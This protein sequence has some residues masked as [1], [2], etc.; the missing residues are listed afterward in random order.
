ML[1]EKTKYNL[2]LYKALKNNALLIEL[3]KILDGFPCVSESDSTLDEDLLKCDIA[4]FCAT[5]AGIVA[6]KH[7]FLAIHIRLDDFFPM[8]P[9]F[10][11][12]QNMLQCSSPLQF[13]DRL[14]EIRRMSNETRMKLYNQQQE[15]A[16]TI[17]APVQLKNIK[18]DLF[19]SKK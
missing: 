3:K 17:F 18:E 11:R 13:A 12:M 6:I 14:Q 1:I 10:D 19:C 2:R 7:G 4:V 16:N 8:N 9:C 5:S 15:F